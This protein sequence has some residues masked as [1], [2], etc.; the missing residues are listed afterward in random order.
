MN[1]G[2]Q[3]YASSLPGYC[4]RIASANF[5]AN[6]EIRLAGLAPDHV[7]VRRVREAARDRLLDARLR[8]VEAFRGALARAER[9]VVLVDVAREQVGRFRVGAREHDRRHAHHVGREPRGDELLHRFLRRHQHLAAHV[10]AL[11]DRREL[12]LEMHAAGAGADH[13]LHELERV[14]HAA[15]AGF[16]VGDDRREVIDVVLVRRGRCPARTGSRPRA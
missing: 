10:A 11:L 13:R 3:L 6:A 12:V 9:L 1:D 8:A 2:E 7:G 14:Q 4:L 15:E 5:F 16:G